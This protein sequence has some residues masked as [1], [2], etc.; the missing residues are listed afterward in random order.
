MKKENLIEIAAFII[1]A[2]VAYMSYSFG[3]TFYRI[4]Y[5]LS[6]GAAFYFPVAIIVKGADE[7]FRKNAPVSE[8]VTTL[9]SIVVFPVL[10]YLLYSYYDAHPQSGGRAARAFTSLIIAIL[11]TWIVVLVVKY[12]FKMFE[13]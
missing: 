4:V 12:I 1:P 11:G 5:A 8:K 10:F 7:D 3:E 9:L 6:I 2:V 13:K